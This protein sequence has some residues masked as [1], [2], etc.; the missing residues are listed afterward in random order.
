MRWRGFSFL[1]SG[2]GRKILVQATQFTMAFAKL[3]PEEI[4]RV[5]DEV[6]AALQR[7]DRVANRDTRGLTFADIE[8]TAHAVGQQ[9]AA[10]I[11]ADA[12]ACAADEQTEF[13]ACP[14]CQNATRVTR[15]KRVLRTLDGPIDYFEPAA[16][17][18]VCRR[19]FFPA[20]S[21]TA[22]R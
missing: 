18:V 19:D 14:Q 6:F 1:P 12:L 17:G 22:S 20:A 15:K 5:A 7:S 10:K 3:S 21:A 16:H 8:R 2:D 13:A 9:V 4:V 11:T